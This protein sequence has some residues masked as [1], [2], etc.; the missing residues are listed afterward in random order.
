MIYYKPPV[1][2]EP[3][4]C[5]CFGDTGRIF[6]DFANCTKGIKLKIK[7]YEGAI[8]FMKKNLEEAIPR[9]ENTVYEH[10]TFYE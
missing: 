8:S 1:I 2:H 4:N 9:E 5:I 3:N 10:P 6:G 7:K